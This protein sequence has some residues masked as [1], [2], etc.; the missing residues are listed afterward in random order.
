MLLLKINNL[1]I[2]KVVLRRQ[3]VIFIVAKTSLFALLGWSGFRLRLGIRNP[4][5]SSCLTQELVP[6]PMSGRTVTLRKDKSHKLAIKELMGRDKLIFGLAWDYLYEEFHRMELANSWVVVWK[7]EKAKTKRKAKVGTSSRCASSKT[8][9][10]LVQLAHS[11]CCLSSLGLYRWLW[12]AN[13]DMWWGYR[14]D[15]A[16]KHQKP[17]PSSTPLCKG[18]NHST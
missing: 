1:I 17:F 2:V 3:K 13:P 9:L 11:N 12:F 16:L 4:I 14:N 15:C 18:H 8:A 5:S 6:N 7:H 10:W